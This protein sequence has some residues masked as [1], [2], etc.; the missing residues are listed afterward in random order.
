[1][2]SL[3][4]L[5]PIQKDIRVDTD[6]LDNNLLVNAGTDI[7]LYWDPTSLSEP[8]PNVIHPL[9]LL[10]DIKLHVFYNDNSRGP[11]VDQVHTLATGVNNT[12]SISVN[13][14][15]ISHS[16]GQT[17]YS[18]IISVEA[19][20]ND[21]HNPNVFDRAQGQPTQ[22]TDVFWI[23]TSTSKSNNFW[24]D[25]KLWFMGESI[26]IG[27]QLL[28]RVLSDFPCPPTIAQART[29]NSGLIED[30]NTKW[31]TFFHPLADKCFHQR[32]ITRYIHYNE[33]SND[34]LSIFI[35]L[36]TITEQ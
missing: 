13:L 19:K 4:N 29:V 21:S 1:M 26:L 32:T 36:F 12:G 35:T 7:T 9:S 8:V 16:S 23:S 28:T 20:G 31:I 6:L 30:A 25:C 11:T 33:L 24:P 15:V 3:Y 10:V 22:W 14:P 17:V 18:S 5:E 2:L 27:N 34:T